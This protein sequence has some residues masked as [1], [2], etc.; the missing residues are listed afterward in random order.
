MMFNT[1]PQPN[2]QNATSNQQATTRSTWSGQRVKRT[3]IGTG[4]IDPSACCENCA[5][6]L[7]CSGPAGGCNCGGYH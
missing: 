2:P 7:E 4:L 1:M 3:T 5:L 6:G